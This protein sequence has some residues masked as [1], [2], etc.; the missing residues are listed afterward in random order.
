MQR[1]NPRVFDGG[2][3]EFVS[4][5]PMAVDSRSTMDHYEDMSTSPPPPDT[6]GES[7]VDIQSRIHIAPLYAGTEEGCSLGAAGTGGHG[8]MTPIRPASSRSITPPSV[9]TNGT[10]E[11]A[12]MIDH[13]DIRKLSLKHKPRN[14]RKSMLWSMSGQKGGHHQ[15]GFDQPPRE[16]LNSPRSYD[17]AARAVDGLLSLGQDRKSPPQLSP[18]SPSPSMRSPYPPSPSPS[19]YNSLIRVSSSDIQTLSPSSSSSSYPYVSPQPQHSP[20]NMERLWAGETS[21]SLRP[22][23]HVKPDSALDLSKVDFWNGNAA[24]DSSGVPMHDDQDEEDQ[25][26]ICM[27]CDDKAT[28][29]HYG[30]ITCEG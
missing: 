10:A 8:I 23:H 22:T 19:H 21:Q 7:K 29:L 2:G 27:I 15:G 12:M 9:W 4:S 5:T 1:S 13:H 16:I 3:D 17:D 11:N 25:P 14:S 30:I 20:L 18:L 28:G 6:S 26:M 24:V